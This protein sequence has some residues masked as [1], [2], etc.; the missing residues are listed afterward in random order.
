MYRSRRIG[1][2]KRGAESRTCKTR[3]SREDGGR[4]GESNQ[5]WLREMVRFEL[6]I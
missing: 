2:V 1:H 5:E 3:R 4:R 6:A